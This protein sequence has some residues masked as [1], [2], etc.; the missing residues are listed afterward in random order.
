[1]QFSEQPPSKQ[2]A[3]LKFQGEKIAEVWF[4]PEGEPWALVFRIPQRSFQNPGIAGRMTAENLLKSVGIAT[5]QVESWRQGDGSPSAQDEPDPQLSN[6]LPQ[7]PQDVAHLELHVRLKPPPQAVVRDESDAPELAAAKLRELEARWKAILGLE[8]TIDTYRIS[9][10]GLR[11]EMEGLLKRMLT[12]DEKL[13]AISTDVVQWNKAKSR[14]HYALPRTKE[15]IHRAT[16]AQGTP[17]RKKLGELFKDPIE[18]HLAPSLVDEVVQELEILRKDRQVL[19]AQGVTV[20][21]ECKAISADVQAAL[22]RLQSNAAARAS[23]KRGA[24]GARGKSF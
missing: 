4:K 22:R 3:V 5:E 6:P 23:K 15:F 12:A 14:I 9:M 21:Q 24:T 10:E 18:A 1:M 13:H 7:P 17:E 2:W 11:V 8:A 19:S 20:H 16:W